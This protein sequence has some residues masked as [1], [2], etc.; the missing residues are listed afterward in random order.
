MATANPTF[1]RCRSARGG[2]MAARPPTHRRR[3][4]WLAPGAARWSSPNPSP[5]PN[6]N[7]NPNPHPHLSP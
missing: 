1:L 5:S 2:S 4:Q 6:P 7:P 3:S